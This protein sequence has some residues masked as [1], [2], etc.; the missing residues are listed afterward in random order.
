M[1]VIDKRSGRDLFLQADNGDPYTTLRNH[2]GD[3][4]YLADILERCANK[5]SLSFVCISDIV[6]AGPPQ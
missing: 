6:T 1:A 4:A 2:L 5:H 3:K